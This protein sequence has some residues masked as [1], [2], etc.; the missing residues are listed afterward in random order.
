[1]SSWIDK[2]FNLKEVPAKLILVLF[3]SSTI[4]LFA[5]ESLIEKLQLSA[6]ISS[7]G[8]FIGITFVI[9]SGFLVIILF[10]LID[11]FFKRKKYSVRI[12]KLI[13]ESIQT[14]DSY[15]K[16]LLREFFIQ[17]KQTLQLPIDNETVTGL[18]NKGVLN[19][20]SPYGFVYIHGTYNT[21]EISKKAKKLITNN[22]LNLPQNPTNEQIDWIR[23]N[24]P[25]WAIAKS[26]FENLINSTL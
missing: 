15:E 25:P 6:F 16:S 2:F 24:R 14:L 26:R 10:N 5:S 23:N 1:M 20:V 12:N 13:I 3:F 21:Y 8:K 7:Y 17:G 4:I 9:T 18:C 11:I 22:D 19:Q